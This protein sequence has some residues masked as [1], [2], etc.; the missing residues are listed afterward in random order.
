MSLASWC[1]LA[2][3]MYSPWVS[4]PLWIAQ[5]AQPHYTRNL[6]IPEITPFQIQHARPMPLAFASHSSPFLLSWREYSARLVS[7]MRWT[8]GVPS[9]DKKAY[10]KI[11]PTA[12]FGAKYLMQRDSRSSGV[13]LPMEGNV[14]QMENCKLEW[15]LQWIGV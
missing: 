6:S 5:G 14:H 3:G 11:F 9:T 4:A 13:S 2:A 10:I 15:P 7:K 8:G 1:V 12:K